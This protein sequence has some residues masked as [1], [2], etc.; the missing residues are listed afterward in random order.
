M[1]KKFYAPIFYLLVFLLLQA[2]VPGKV[3]RTTRFWE[4]ALT[5]PLFDNPF[6]GVLVWDPQSGDT[7]VGKNSAR[8]F[9][10]ASNIKILTLYTSLHLL[11]ERMPALRYLRRKDTLYIEGTGDPSLL[12]PYFRDSTAIHFLKGQPET[13]VLCTGNWEDTRWGAGWAWEDYD[14]PYAPERSALPVY[15]N[16][17]GVYRT[18]STR[19]RPAYFAPEVHPI[20]YPVRRLLA[21]NQF[22]V[23]PETRD[24]LLIP[25]I[26]DSVVVRGLL[27]DATGKRI[28]T[29]VHMPE[30]NA[31]TLYGIARDSLLKRM[32]R[33]SDNFLA[34]QLLLTA[35][36]MLGK[37]LNGKKVREY[38]LSGPLS[39]L[40][41]APVWVDGSGLSRY[42]LLSPE[43]VVYVLHRLYL[44]NDTNRLFD[45]FAAGGISGT[46]KDYYGHAQGPY[47]FAKTGTLSNN[48]CLSGYLKTRSGK[49]LIFSFMH[50]HFTR[51]SEEIKAVMQQLLENLRDTY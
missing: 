25:F 14:S 36:G 45:Y 4:E 38:M 30:G 11:P 16:M 10:P 49:I 44:E 28:I 47:V 37:N 7:L 50:N 21:S 42:N 26:S 23:P 15:G 31:D 41:Q 48:H 19:V 29:Q 12:H 46:L 33:E 32:M 9:T 5:K 18:D 6:T 17:V 39:N 51:S 34:E 8:Y 43:D 24:S 35:S 13:I 27:E 40:P 3:S 1:A 2:C 22:F 20:R